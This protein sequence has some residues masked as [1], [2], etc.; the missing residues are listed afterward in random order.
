MDK[1]QL[2]ISYPS[3]A[4]I[5]TTIKKIV[6]SQVKIKKRED[7]IYLQQKSKQQLRRSY[8]SSAEV[9]TYEGIF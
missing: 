1:W 7:H 6:S 8:L 2:R 3:S 4:E 5:K 9:K